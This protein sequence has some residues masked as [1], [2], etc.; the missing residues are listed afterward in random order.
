M[1]RFTRLHVLITIVGLI[2]IV[3]GALLWEE[4]RIDNTGL[5]TLQH[6]QNTQHLQERRVASMKDVRQQE[7]VAMERLRKTVISSVAIIGEAYKPL[8]DQ[9]GDIPPIAG[10]LHEAKSYIASQQYDLAMSSAQESWKALKLFRAKAASVG[11]NY[12]VVRGDTLWQIAQRHS[13]VKQ[14]PAWV[15]IWKANKDLIKDFNRIE[16]GWD[17]KIPP[18]PSQYLLPYWKPRILH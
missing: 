3:W 7:D 1:I 13:P 10:P 14:G 18:K 6:A 17:L 4:N 16:V 15:T 12:H 8:H 11:V 5:E 2:C 9:Y